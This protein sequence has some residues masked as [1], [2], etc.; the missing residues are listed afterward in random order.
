MAEVIIGEIP[1]A[2]DSTKLLWTARC[3]DADHD[4]LG[5]SRPGIKRRRPEPR[6]SKPNTGP[7]TGLEYMAVDR[8][9]DWEGLQERSP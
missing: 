9:P 4:L 5:T 2:E 8:G 6:T 1:D 3:D 7:A